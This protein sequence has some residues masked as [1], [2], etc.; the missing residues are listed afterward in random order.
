MIRRG[1]LALIWR[2][3]DHNGWIQPRRRKLSVSTGGSVGIPRKV[4]RA[5][6]P[7][8]LSR[9][10]KTVAVAK[11]CPDRGCRGFAEIEDAEFL[12]VEPTCYRVVA[13]IDLDTR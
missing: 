13:A 7:D 10:N 6:F 4:S 3:H 12:L 1:R 9:N 11:E 5:E 2:R 8:C